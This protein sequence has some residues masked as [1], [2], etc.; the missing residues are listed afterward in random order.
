MHNVNE[1]VAIYHDVAEQ[2]VSDIIYFLVRFGINHSVGET[3]FPVPRNGNMIGHDLA[4]QFMNRLSIAGRTDS[5][6][7]AF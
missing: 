7:S 3:F 6:Q 4:T 1:H 2:C 5:F